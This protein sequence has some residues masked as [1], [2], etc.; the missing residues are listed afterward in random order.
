MLIE[1][2]LLKYGYSNFKLEIL[3]YCDKDEVLSREQFYLD[4]LKPEY[5]ILKKAGSSLGFKHSEET[6]AKFKEI[7]KNR[8]YS[9]ER[10][11]KFASLNLN[12]PEEFKERLRARLLELNINKGHQIEVINVST[13]E[14]TLY[15][16]RRQ[17]A[18]ALDNSH[19][20]IRRHL[21]SKKLFKGTYKLS[22]V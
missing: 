22:K 11:A 20:T 21:K 4:L 8:I 14:T 19:T 13:N 6:I 18:S 1:K 17:A 12:R 2:A 7:S 3:E 16:T 15:S 9:E 10:K 5:N